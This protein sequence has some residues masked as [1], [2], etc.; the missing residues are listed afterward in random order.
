MDPFASSGRPAAPTGEVVPRRFHGLATALRARADSDGAI[1]P[2]DMADE[3]TLEV[4]SAG[5]A[6]AALAPGLP[7]S[8]VRWC[9][10]GAGA[11]AERRA[12][13]A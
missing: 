4:T 6:L 5:S 7:E 8:Q 13:A 2:L 9:A 11:L 3:S 12:V 1:R 10:I